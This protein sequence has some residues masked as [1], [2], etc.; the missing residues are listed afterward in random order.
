MSVKRK[1]WKRSRQTTALVQR[2]R[3]IIRDAGY[4]EELAVTPLLSQLSV[5]VRK[6]E[7]MFNVRIDKETMEIVSTYELAYNRRR[8][9]IRK[10]YRKLV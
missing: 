8:D 6:D 10:V 4:D 9:S 5:L 3:S 7:E 1:L 2:L